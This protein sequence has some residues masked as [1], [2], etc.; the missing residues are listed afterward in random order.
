MM[1]DRERGR[2]EIRPVSDKRTWRLI[3][4]GP[5]SGDWNM[6][7]DAFLV[8]SATLPVLRSYSWS[9]PT[10]SLGFHQDYSGWL[11]LDDKEADWLKK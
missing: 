11:D 2:L 1:T 6:A 7:V 8:D 9:R 5:G 10:V 3:N 4:T